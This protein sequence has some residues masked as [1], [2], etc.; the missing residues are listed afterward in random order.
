MLS[1]AVLEEGRKN[2]PGFIGVFAL[3]ELPQFIGPKPQLPFSFIVNTQQRDL[4]GQHWLAVSCENYGIAL[5]FDPLGYYYPHVITNYLILEN[6]HNIVF[7]RI[8]Y[9]KPNTNVC[10]KLC[11]DFLDLIKDKTITQKISLM[12]T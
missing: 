11:L 3:D 2:V 4:P 10:G 6:F 7:N 9:Q 8:P 1:S 5:I 12:T